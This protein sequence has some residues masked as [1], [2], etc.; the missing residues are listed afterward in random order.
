MTGAG[1]DRGV[2]GDVEEALA[3]GT[4]AGAEALNAE[5]IRQGQRM[6]T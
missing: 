2:V 6:T 3:D 1:L 4:A 5:S